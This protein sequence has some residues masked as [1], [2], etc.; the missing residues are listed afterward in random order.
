MILTQDY[1]AN[2]TQS[3]IAVASDGEKF[4]ILLFRK[5]ID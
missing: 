4:S 2:E 3:A 1:S 5:I